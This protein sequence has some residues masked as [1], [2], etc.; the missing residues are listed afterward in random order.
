MLPA[1]A[2]RDFAEAVETLSSLLLSQTQRLAAD[3][4]D[5]PLTLLE[6]R[7]AWNLAGAA[8]AL[9]TGSLWGARAIRAKVESEKK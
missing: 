3:A 7:V 9:G 8:K 4:A 6:S 5:R 2:Q 1:K